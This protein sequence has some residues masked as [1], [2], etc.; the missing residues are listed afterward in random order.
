MP[1][2]QILS[3]KIS[4]VIVAAGYEMLDPHLLTEYGYG[5]HPDILTSLEFERLINSAGPTGG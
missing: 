4:S 5:S 3:R 2:E 1:P